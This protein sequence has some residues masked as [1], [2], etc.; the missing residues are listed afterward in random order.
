MASL[1]YET[2]SAFQAVITKAMGSCAKLGLDPTEA[3]VAHTVNRDGKDVR[4]YKLNRF[5]CEDF[6]QR[7]LSRLRGLA[8]AD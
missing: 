6:D 4:T 7:E 2:W 8:G 5:A 3:F 1:G